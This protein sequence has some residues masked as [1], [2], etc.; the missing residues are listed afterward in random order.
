MHAGH[1]GFASLVSR[2]TRRRFLG[3]AGSAAVPALAACGGPATGTGGAPVGGDRTKPSSIEYLTRETVYDPY[4]AEIVNRFRAT[5]PQIEVQRD[6]QSGNDTFNPKLE[7]L[8]AAGTPPDAA[9]VTGS[10]YHGQAARGLF[11]DLTPYVNR[12]KALDAADFVPF[13]LESAKFRGKLY[14]FP[15]DGGV[16]DLFWN[17]RLLSGAG[18]KPPD[19]KQAMTWPQLQELGKQLTKTPPAV[20]EAQT[21][22]GL[23]LGANRLWYLLPWQM[24]VEL[25]DKD[26][27]QMR[28]NDPRAID[29]LQFVA[30]LQGKYGVWRPPSFQGP[31]TSLTNGKVA[32][33]QQGSW[34]FGFIRKQMLDAGLDFDVAPL[35]T[36]PGRPRLTVGWGSGTTIM[37]GAKNKAAAWELVKFIASKEICEYLL[38]EGL[39]QPVRKSQANSRAWRGQTPPYSYDVPLDDAKTARTPPF[40][41]AMNELPALME[42]ALADAYAG[43]S[44]VKPLVE[45]WLP[46]INQLLQDYARRFP[47]K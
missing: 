2:P 11:D 5:Y 22:F 40:A 9:Y 36:F 27:T 47:P 17:A 28:L 1:A 25:F 41:P 26:Y 24:G 4:F 34:Q 39:V 15:F 8:V 42:K 16:L 18:H 29:A 12:D 44:A 13:W 23:G 14:F 31:A 19:V 20:P 6:H 45:S 37:A 30:D 35:P 7:T 33:S 38:E 46:Q 32:I 3:G 21:Q 10:T 43:K